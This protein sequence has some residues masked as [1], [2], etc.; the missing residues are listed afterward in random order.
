MFWIYKLL[1]PIDDEN[2]NENENIYSIAFKS[3]FQIR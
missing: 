1:S 3:V 2:E